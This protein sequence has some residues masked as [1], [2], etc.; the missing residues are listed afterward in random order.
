M[1]IL[2]LAA[3]GFMAGAAATAGTL[4]AT[5]IQKD[6]RPSAL[7]IR[8]VFSS[9]G[10]VQ[11]RKLRKHVPAGAVRA[12]RSLPY[13]GAPKGPALD[14]FLPEDA[15]E[16][17]LPVVVWVHGG[18]WISGCKEN[19]AP[20]LE[21]LASNGFAVVGAGYTISPEANYPQAVTELNSA[22]GYL[23]EHAAEYNLDPERIVL[24]GD[25]AGAQLAAQLALIIT[26]PDYAR[27]TGVEPAAAREHVRGM[28][29]FC[30]VYDLKTMSRLTGPLGWGFRTAL[31]AY[32]GSKD[33]A[34]TPAAEH[35]SILEHVGENFPPSFISGGN[36]D[37]LTE[38]QSK[39]LAAKLEELGVPVVR[40]FWDRDH[41]P[42][43]GHEY[44]F[45]LQYKDARMALAETL[46]FL[47]AVTGS[48][49]VPVRS[50]LEATA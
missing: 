37:Y 26:D 28:L 38:Q 8:G 46:N 12:H 21:I 1:K 32:T 39:P 31:W 9:G 48:Q 27:R 47:D 15:G 10:K 41:R 43:L 7:F 44:Q 17:P 49:S 6:P 4:A 19:I 25:S 13:I 36:A 29:L 40:R 5:V 42:A 45:K 3:A 20:Y 50:D 16:G 24:A 14:V 34:S 2:P 23:R 11:L 30:G 33:W 18:A 22:L 35:M